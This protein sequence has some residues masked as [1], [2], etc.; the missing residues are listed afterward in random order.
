[1]SSV[2]NYATSNSQTSEPNSWTNLSGSLGSTNWSNPTAGSLCEA[3]I[4][5][6]AFIRFFFPIACPLT[7][8]ITGIKAETT[9]SFTDGSPRDAIT[10]AQLVLNGIAFPNDKGTLGGTV[11]GGDGDRWGQ[12]PTPEIINDPSFGFQFCVAVSAFAMDQN[13]Y[14][15]GC[16]LTFYYAT[17]ATDPN[18]ACFRNAT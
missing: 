17:P 14:C 12:S 10:H 5:D 18:Y 9:L 4:D 15:G 16:R 1:M 2:L 6:S 13:V 7:A 3:G 11:F 8:H